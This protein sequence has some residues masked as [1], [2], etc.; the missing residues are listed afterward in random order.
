MNETKQK[1]FDTSFKSFMKKPKA[2][3]RADGTI[4][5]A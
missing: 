4:K 3:I 2:I 5:I 1:Q